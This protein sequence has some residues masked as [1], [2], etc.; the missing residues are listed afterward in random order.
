MISYYPLGF[1]VVPDVYIND[2]RSSGF[3]LLLNV[4]F[5]LLFFEKNFF[6]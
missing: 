5:I 4:K 3:D 6:I 2:H 1:P